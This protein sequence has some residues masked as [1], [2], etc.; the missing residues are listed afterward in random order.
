M[1][2]TQPPKCNNFS[3]SVTQWLIYDAYM[4]EIEA[5]AKKV[6]IAS[7]LNDLVSRRAATT[8]LSDALE[9]YFLLTKIGYSVEVFS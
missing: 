1:I 7:K 9:S 2:A 3:E 8:L 5:N 4:A 6:E